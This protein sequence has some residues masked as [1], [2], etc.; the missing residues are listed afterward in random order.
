MSAFCSARY[1]GLLRSEVRTDVQSAG[2]PIPL[3]SCIIGMGQILIADYVQYILEGMSLATDSPL[4]ESYSCY[5]T[6]SHGVGFVIGQ[7]LLW[8]E[9]VRGNSAGGR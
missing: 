4:S 9:S 1:C 7:V 8:F 3:G 2:N 6:V 5:W